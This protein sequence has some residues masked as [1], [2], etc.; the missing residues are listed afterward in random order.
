MNNKIGHTLWVIPEGYIPPGSHGPAPEFT[1]HEA[2]C[3]LNT[4]EA[5]AHLTVTIYYTDRDPVGPYRLTVV[6]RRT[7]H[8]RFN[9]LNDPEP[10]PLGTPYSSVIESDIPI[11]VQHT[12]LD[13]RQSENALMTTIAYPCPN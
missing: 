1:S 8:F 7:Q 5:D 4:N 12:R 11:I 13:S 10:V 6:A 9:N 3:V 2:F